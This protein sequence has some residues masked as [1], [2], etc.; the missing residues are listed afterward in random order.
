MLL[1]E[2]DHQGN[3]VD[4]GA[5]EDSADEDTK[6]DEK[7][8]GLIAMA[9]NLVPVDRVG[10]NV[11]KV[12]E[13][14][15]WARHLNVERLHLVIHL[16]IALAIIPH[17]SECFAIKVLSLHCFALITIVTEFTTPMPNPHS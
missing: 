14:S 16:C 17:L 4:A 8:N 6:L 11:T 10:N 5:A 9:G 15:Q 13:V 3:A 7:S 2:V 12:E 1:G